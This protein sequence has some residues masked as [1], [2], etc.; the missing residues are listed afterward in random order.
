MDMIDLSIIFAF[1]Y[2]IANGF[3]FPKRRKALFSYMFSGIKSI[4]STGRIF[5]ITI[6]IA[7]PE[8][9]PF[10]IVIAHHLTQY[11]RLVVTLLV[12]NLFHITCIPAKCSTVC[13]IRVNTIG[14]Q[15]TSTTQYGATNSMIALFYNDTVDIS[16]RH[17]GT[18]FGTLDF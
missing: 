5:T 14:L 7:R 1:T 2:N 9:C 3:I 6:D 12:G 8:C 15:L 17:I 4:N 16:Y 13:I 18:T 10:I 11:Y